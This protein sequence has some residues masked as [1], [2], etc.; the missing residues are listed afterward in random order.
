MYLL[1]RLP[2]HEDLIIPVRAFMR[3]ELIPLSCSP[4]AF[5]V[6]SDAIF[7]FTFYVTFIVSFIVTFE[8]TFDVL[9]QVSGVRFQVS[10]VRCQV[11]CFCCQVSG[12]RCLESSVSFQMSKSNLRRFKVTQNVPI[13]QPYSSISDNSRDLLQEVKGDQ[14]G[15]NWLSLTVIHIPDL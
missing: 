13:V 11:S 2:H 3:S 12:V 15:V 9:C 7:D 8:V 5:D 6:T 14:R 10:G 4:L 1:N